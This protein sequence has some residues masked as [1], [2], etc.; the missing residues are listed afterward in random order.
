MQDKLADG[1]I[2]SPDK[3]SDG[4]Q[5][6]SVPRRVSLQSRVDDGVRAPP[7]WQRRYT[8]FLRAITDAEALHFDPDRKQ[9]TPLH[10]LFGVFNRGNKG[11]VF[12]DDLD[13]NFR[14]VVGLKF[15]D[16]MSELIQKRMTDG[17]L[18]FNAFEDLV[19]HELRHLTFPS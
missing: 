14:Q 18:H 2:R 8:D 13:A 1:L 5:A 19:F 10:T 17:G 6:G 15:D 7:P 4:Q 9:Q 11:H 16:S 3:G 12:F